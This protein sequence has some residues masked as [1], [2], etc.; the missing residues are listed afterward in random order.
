MMLEPKFGPK[1]NKH[2]AT[3]IRYLRVISLTDGKD[4]LMTADILSTHKI[5]TKF[6]VFL[7][8]FLLCL[9]HFL[10]FTSRLRERNIFGIKT[11]KQINQNSKILQSLL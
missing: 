10:V 11:P 2:G 9:V 4:L 5:S 1:F 6:E 7:E 3:A 8:I